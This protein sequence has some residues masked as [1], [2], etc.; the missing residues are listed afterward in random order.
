MGILGYLEYLGYIDILHISII[1]Y[2]FLYYIYNLLFWEK[3][4]VFNNNLTV[5]FIIVNSYKFISI[6]YY[7]YLASNLEHL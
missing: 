4:D 6:P 5:I 2:I 7:I 1:L 3:R